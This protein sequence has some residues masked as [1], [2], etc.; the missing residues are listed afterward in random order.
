[1]VTSTVT[2][3]LGSPYSSWN[4]KL[5]F[6]VIGFPI[7]SCKVPFIRIVLNTTASSGVA[8]TVIIACCLSAVKSFIWSLLFR[9]L[10][11]PRYV[12]LIVTLSKSVISVNWMIVSS[13]VISYNLE[14]LPTVTLSSFVPSVMLAPTF[15][16]I[17]SFTLTPIVTFPTVLFLIVIV[18]FVGI[19]L[20][21]N[22]VLFC[23]GAILSTSGITVP[24]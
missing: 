15:S 12:T 2:F 14:L 3:S 22:S 11:V 19:L 20:T 16:S 10:L 6:P 23:D 8:S 17:Y 13:P 5:T 21:E 1:M 9:Y 18:V 4:V 7:P 24:V